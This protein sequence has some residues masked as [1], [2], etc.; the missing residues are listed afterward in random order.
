LPNIGISSYFA[1]VP[2]FVATTN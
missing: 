1:E 2:L